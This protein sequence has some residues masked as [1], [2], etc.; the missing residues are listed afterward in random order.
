[1]FQKRLRSFMWLATL[2]TSCSLAAGICFYT[3]AAATA[4][5]SMARQTGMPL[6]FQKKT[7]QATPTA[8]PARTPA[9]PARPKATAPALSPTP[10]FM[11]AVLAHYRPQAPLMGIALEGFTDAAGLH[12]VLAL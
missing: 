10:T 11:P 3:Y 7:P 9:K 12:E 8:V 4:N 5:T 6:A 1:M 2:A